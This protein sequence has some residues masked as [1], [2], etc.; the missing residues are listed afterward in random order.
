[1]VFK[2]GQ[3]VSFIDDAV[4]GVVLAI[5]P[6]LI[7][8]ETED[9]FTLQAE[10]KELIV[11]G[12]L[13]ELDLDDALISE[14]KREEEQRSQPG[15]IPT[16]R[17]KT[18]PPMEVDLHAHQLTDNEK[19]MSKHAILNLQLDTARGQLEFAI[20]KG[21]QKIVFI[22]GVGEGVLRME[23]E[24]LLSRYEVKFYDADYKKYGLGATEVYIFQNQ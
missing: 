9:G 8:I 17:S 23:L 10:P 16:K 18:V 2:K 14:I 1:M 21:I 12:N 15:K 22:H 13:N 6:D 20:R 19:G 7:T 5:G 4:S 3:K 11:E 24:T